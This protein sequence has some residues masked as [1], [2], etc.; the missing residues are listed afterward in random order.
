MAKIPFDLDKWLADKSQKVETRDGR[1]VRIVCWD[2]KDKKY[3]V[4][5]L[6]EDPIY[7]N[8]E[9]YSCYTST[10]RFYD[11]GSNSNDLFLVIPEPTEFEKEIEA[12]NERFPEV[13]FAKLS[14]IA[15]RF[16]DLGKEEALKDL[17][18]WKHNY[19]FYSDGTFLCNGKTVLN[20]GK[21]YI[22]I[23]ELKKLPGFEE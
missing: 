8:C 23:D 10:G 3:P 18:R 15:K 14:R 9:V 7:P 16:Y 13:S 20:V 4:I 19:A 2:R 5:A 1:P 21:S 12:T 22:N 11:Y 17:P 6:Y